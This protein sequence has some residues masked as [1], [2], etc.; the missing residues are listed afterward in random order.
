M[1]NCV[2]YV[3][4]GCWRECTNLHDRTR[5][6]RG[7]VD[8]QISPKSMAARDGGSRS[9]KSVGICRTAGPGTLPGACRT[10][11]PRTTIPKRT[12]RLNIAREPNGSE[13]SSLGRNFGKTPHSAYIPDYILGCSPPFDSSPSRRSSS[14][15]SPPPDPSIHL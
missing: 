15:V 4:V 13:R 11:Y 1:T 7:L 9:R 5:R 6:L 12:F 3:N 2:S 14:D 8:A 10:V